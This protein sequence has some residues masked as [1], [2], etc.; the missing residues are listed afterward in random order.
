MRMAE[1]SAMPANTSGNPPTLAQTNSDRMPTM[2]N[3]NT[4]TPDTRV[5]NLRV[6]KPA[7]SMSTAPTSVWMP[8]YEAATASCTP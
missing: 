7:N 2:K 5:P 6:M 8:K 1:V 4:S 3:P